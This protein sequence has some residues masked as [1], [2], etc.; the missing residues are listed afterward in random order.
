[1]LGAACLEHSNFA[2]VSEGLHFPTDA[3]VWCSFVW[4]LLASPL[5]RALSTTA[6]F[7]VPVRP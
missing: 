6:A 5:D 7:Q 1:L 3:G 2:E 4:N